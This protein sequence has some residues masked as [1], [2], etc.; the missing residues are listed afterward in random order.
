MVKAHYPPGSWGQTLSD[1]VYHRHKRV[2]G[3][4]QWRY[5]SAEHTG[6][7]LF[8]GASRRPGFTMVAVMLSSVAR[9]ESGKGSS[10][11]NE[12]FKSPLHTLEPI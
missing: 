12:D 1:T 9:S 4:R 11:Y 5:S 6:Q 8:P 3:N 2:E 10:V 7:P